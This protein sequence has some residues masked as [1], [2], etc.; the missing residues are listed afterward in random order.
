[1]HDGGDCLGQQP[2]M[3]FADS[4]DLRQH[5]TEAGD[6]RPTCAPSCLDNWLTDK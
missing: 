6:L 1:M 3:G 4:E 5:W 2:R